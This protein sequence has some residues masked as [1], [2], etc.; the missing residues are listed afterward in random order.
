[1]QLYNILYRLVDINAQ[2]GELIVHNG[3][4]VGN[5]V[6]HLDN[7]IEHTC[8][9]EL[10]ERNAL[11]Y[12]LTAV[13]V[14]LNDDLHHLELLVKGNIGIVLMI[15][16]LLQETNSYNTGSLDDQLLVVGKNVRTEALL[17]PSACFPH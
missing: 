3:L 16:V 6:L 17:S 11:I 5:V 13:I 7:T 12:S 8:F 10:A 15:S 14:K 1:M 4:V 9:K 2:V